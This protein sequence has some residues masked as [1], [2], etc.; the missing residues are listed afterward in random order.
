[1]EDIIFPPQLAS[2]D[3]HTIIEVEGSQTFTNPHSNWIEL[4]LISL[5]LGN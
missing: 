3:N 2:D 4:N 1:M 5:L